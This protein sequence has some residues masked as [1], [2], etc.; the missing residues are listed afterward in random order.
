M[1]RT[2]GV[3]TGPEHTVEELRACWPDYLVE[4]LSELEGLAI[5][6]YMAGSR[7]PRPQ[8]TP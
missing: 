1:I 6:Q 8:A 5:Y 2:A 3:A 4:D 7:G